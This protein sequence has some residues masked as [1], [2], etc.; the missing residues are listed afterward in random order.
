MLLRHIFDLTELIAILALMALVLAGWGRLAVRFIGLP[1][2]ASINTLEIWFGFASILG[3][4][5][6][7]N[8]IFPVDW[9]MSLVLAVIG[10]VTLFTSERIE[11]KQS[12][13]VLVGLVRIYPWAAASMLMFLLVCC[14]QAMKSP[15][16]YDSG[17]Y[18]FQSIRWLNEYP[19][20]PGLG[21]LHGRL[22]FNQS[23]LGYIALANIAPIWNKG[24]AAGGL[25]LLLLTF[26]SII[27]ADL[28]RLKGGVL[29]FS[30]LIL[31]IW[32]QVVN[33]SSPTPDIPIALLQVIFF[34][35]L[36][37]I[38]LA[39]EQDQSA[40]RYGALLFLLCVAIV[41]IKLSAAMYAMT[42]IC[43]SLVLQYKCFLKY[44][45]VALKT[46]AVCTLMF[47]VHLIRGYI[48]SGV[49]LYPSTIAGAWGLNWAMPIEAVKV[50][51]NWIYS[52]ARRPW[53][54]PAMV[55]GNWQWFPYWLKA[56]GIKTWLIFG[57]SVVINLLHLL[58]SRQYKVGAQHSDRRIYII[59][60]PLL[61]SVIFWF[62]T[63][64]EPR[65][66]GL[67]LELLAILSA[68]LFILT[69]LSIEFLRFPKT[70][71]HLK[72]LQILMI[73]MIALSLQKA[74]NF[75]YVGWEKIP[76]TPMIIKITDSGLPVRVPLK[77]DQCWDE[78]LPC[79]PYFLTSLRTR[80]EAGNANFNSG[81]SSKAEYNNPKFWRQ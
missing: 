45:S 62:F 1:R 18:H 37:K 25:F 75:S 63:A 36:L 38:I 40:M 61:A 74:I 44:R 47:A 2:M 14:S 23:Y 53:L 60:V 6:F 66:L 51:A 78:T 39:E 70:L 22:A 67:I 15:E 32:S 76:S 79:T 8:L 80:T 72:Q 9:R 50:E 10:V 12:A 55:L 3:V 56:L 43:V 20:V 19:I 4:V 81:F 29:L 41:T 68:W 46:L 11:W 26:A 35:L 31:A 64:P 49:P 34:I 33:I 17:L 24:Y 5:E 58:V 54:A 42:S 30:L 27:E 57:V 28:L 73:L 7:L 48:Y 71:S 13:L 65:F 69:L 21:N 59:Y 52:W 77:G 16:I